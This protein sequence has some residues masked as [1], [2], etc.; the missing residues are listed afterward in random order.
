[1]STSRPATTAAEV[2]PALLQA[3]AMTLRPTVGEPVDVETRV[4]DVEPYG[5]SGTALVVACP[6][7]L[8]PDEHHFD[9]S[10]TWTYP[11]GRMVCPVSTRPAQ[12]H[13]GRVWLLR[14][15]AAPTRLQQRT[16]FRARLAVPVA[17]TWPLPTDEAAD[18]DEAD[19]HATAPTSL[20]GVAVDLSE[21]GVLAAT[22][23]PVPDPGTRVEATIRIDGDNLAQPARVVR[24]VRFAGGGV[25]VA[26]SFA[27][28]TVHGD[29]IRRAVFE[30][31]RRRRRP[32]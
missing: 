2:H 8:D 9:A 12:R 13:Y 27:D 23:G 29:R 31:E 25:G 3:V 14:P 7:G 4:L 10:V 19:E 11:L 28:P 6:D 5:E 15:S 22:Q 24:H 16:F 32:R 20:L 18:D 26:V 1:M 17:L 30:T 21:G